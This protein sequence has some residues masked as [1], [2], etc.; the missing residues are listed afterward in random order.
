MSISAL[1]IA[2]SFYF[3]QEEVYRFLRAK[4]KKLKEDHFCQRQKPSGYK[5]KS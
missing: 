5:K 4:A 1:K 2:N 3:T